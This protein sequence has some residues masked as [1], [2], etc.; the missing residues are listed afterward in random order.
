MLRKIIDGVHR[1]ADGIVNWYLV[2]DDD[3]VTLVDTGWPRSFP[4]LQQ[5]LANL[6]HSPSDVRA[7]LLTHG[8]GDHLGAAEQARTAFSAP[9]YAHAAE[10]GRVQGTRPGSSSFALVPSLLPTLW[11]PTALGFV[12]H[13]TAHGFLT[14]RWVKDVVAVTGGE[15]L[16]VPGRPRVVACPGHTEGHAAYLLP[17]RGVL[18]SGDALVTLD[19][20]TRERGPRLLP[21]AVNAHPARARAS[22]DALAR[23]EA[24]LLLPGHGEPWHGQPAEAAELARA[25]LK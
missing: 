14:P 2:E 18:F 8:H 21:D 4:K 3:G 22:L 6:G 25:A 24:T 17:D 20:L 7:I 16:D 19:V 13:A 10:V 15:E 5:A 9:V 12:L 1:Y 23:T 11:R